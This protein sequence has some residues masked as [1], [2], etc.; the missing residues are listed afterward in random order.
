PHGCEISRWAHARIPAPLRRRVARMDMRAYVPRLLERGTR[1]DLLFTNSLVYLGADE[2]PDFL[3]HCNRLAS[4]LHFYS[5][6][7][8]AYEPGDR[9][10]VTLRSR[11]WWRERLMAAGFEPTRSPYFW[12]STFPEPDRV[13]ARAPRAS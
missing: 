6:T 7:R 11:D 2:L 9:Y 1:F 5:S 3:V 8:E 13:S 4:H 12:R 10:R